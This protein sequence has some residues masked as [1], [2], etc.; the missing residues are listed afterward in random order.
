MRISRV[1]GIIAA[2][3]H[4]A[5]KPLLQIGTIPIIRRIVISFQ[6]AGIFPIVVI[7][8]VDEDQVKY[9]LS[10]YGVIFVPYEEHE[11]PKLMDCART[12]LNYLRG[13][14]DRIV[15]TPVNIPMFTPETLNKLIR[16]EGDFVSPSCNGQNGHP[17][18][19]SANVIDEV[20]A[21]HGSIGLREALRPLADRRVFVEVN[22]PGILTT[23]RNEQELLKQLSSHNQAILRPRIKLSFDREAPFFNSRLKLLLFLISDTK[24]MR[25]ACAAMA[26]SYGKAWVMINEL[27][28]ELGYFVVERSHGGKMGGNT[29]LTEQGEAFLLAYQQYEEALFQFAQSQFTNMFIMPKILK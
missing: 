17:F 22:D 6:Q 5:A 18:V 20:L 2:A 3:S 24:N 4:A 26:I 8:G 14:C 10:D 11:N 16:A 13:K 21:Y 12:G 15:F 29:S 1:G 23:V 25:K 9:E 19:L 28:R 7:T 27:E